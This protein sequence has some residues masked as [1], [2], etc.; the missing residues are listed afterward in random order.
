[1]APV[2][3]TYSTVIL[4]FCNEST[5]VALVLREILAEDISCRIK[6]ALGPLP[7]EDNYSDSEEGSF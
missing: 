3:Q 2:E 7:L 6:N 1:M 5:S 4:E